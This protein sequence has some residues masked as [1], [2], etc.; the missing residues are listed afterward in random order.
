MRTDPLTVCP[1]V[2]TERSTHLSFS[3]SNSAA[4]AGLM[5]AALSQVSLVNGLWDIPAASRCLTRSRPQMVGSGRKIASSAPAGGVEGVVVGAAAMAAALTVNWRVGK[6]VP[7][8]DAFVQRI[9]PVRFKPALGGGD[10]TPCFPDQLII[11]R[12]EPDPSG[13]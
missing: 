5:I 8:R 2:P 13:N 12:V 9:T 7:S 11:R 6:A 4:V 10:R 1:P 3:N